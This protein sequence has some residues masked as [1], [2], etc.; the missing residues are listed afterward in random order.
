MHGGEVKLSSKRHGHGGRLCPGLL[1]CQGL[2]ATAESLLPYHPHPCGD[3]ADALET[4]VGVPGGMRGTQP[5]GTW[6]VLG[7]RAVALVLL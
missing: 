4:G 1:D 3:V 6:F 7:R 2:Q 5:S